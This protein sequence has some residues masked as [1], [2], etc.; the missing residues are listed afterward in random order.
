MLFSCYC[1]CYCLQS[2]R[3]NVQREEWV[4]HVLKTYV[5]VSDV[6][7]Q[8]ELP[9][10]PEVIAWMQTSDGVKAVLLAS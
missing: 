10:D 7:Q 5:G 6:Y 9:D 8:E 4:R 3:F 2:S 1:L